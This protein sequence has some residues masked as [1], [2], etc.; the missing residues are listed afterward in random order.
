MAQ[1]TAEI[2][3]IIRQEYEYAADEPSMYTAGVRMGAKFGFKPPS[4]GSISKHINKAKLAGNGWE[5]RGSMSGINLAAHRKADALVTSD[6]SLRSEQQQSI[7]EPEKRSE[8][9]KADFSSLGKE[10]IKRDESEDLRAEVIARHRMEWKLVGG[11]RNESLQHRKIDHK[12]SLE[13]ARLAKLTADTILIQQ[14]GERKSW[15][16]DEYNIDMTK[17]TD[18][19]LMDIINGKLPR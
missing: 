11:L 6:G 3:K 1:L 7:S 13:L 2:W 10:L 17:L 5:R 18:E 19:Q 4:N 12:K 15:G 16:L 9:D 14:N 8:V